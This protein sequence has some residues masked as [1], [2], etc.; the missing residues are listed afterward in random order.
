MLEL[1]PHP[2]SR[3]ADCPACGYKQSL[4]ITQK[5]GKP[6]YHC[7]AGCGKAATWWRRDG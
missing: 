2:R 3:Y 4:S 6:L 5:D 7:H 1:A